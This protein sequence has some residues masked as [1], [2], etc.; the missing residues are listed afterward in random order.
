MI[1]KMNEYIIIVLVLIALI[2]IIAAIIWGSDYFMTA[3]NMSLFSLLSAILYLLLQAP[4]VALT[5]AAIGVCIST[6]IML[7]FIKK[8]KLF[9][10]SIKLE[11]LPIIV[12][13]IFFTL[14]FSI[15][16][17]LPEFGSPNVTIS[18]N[19][20]L[21]YYFLHTQND[22]QINSLVAAILASFRGFDTFGETVVIY[23]ALVS[24][25]LILRDNKEAQVNETK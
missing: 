25:L 21:K 11:I 18:D 23:T 24:V 6:V 20:V 2:I 5:E 16:S 3:V 8:L 9:K 15:I 12:C 17:Y 7:A 1:I 19:D 10:G 4:D 22:I 14:L 13:I